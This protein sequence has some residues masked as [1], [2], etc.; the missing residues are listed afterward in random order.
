LPR[1]QFP[2]PF[3]ALLSWQRVWRARGATWVKFFPPTLSD[4]TFMNGKNGRMAAAQRLY[5]SIW[6]QGNWAKEDEH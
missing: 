6:K 5:Y 1:S 3:V 4:D 2:C